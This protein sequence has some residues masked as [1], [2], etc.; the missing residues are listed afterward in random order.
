MG[1]FDKL[2]GSKPS[3]GAQPATAAVPKTEFDHL[4][5]KYQ[6]VLTVIDQQGVRLSNLHAENGKLVIV[7]TA[8]TQEAANRVWDQ[9]KLFSNYQQDLLIDLKVDPH[10][11]QGASAASLANPQA[12]RT[13]V[14]Q[15]G[16]TL[17]KIARQFYGDANDYM[18][19]F[20]ANRDKL[21]D[22][23]KIMPGQELRIP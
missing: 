8:P 14:V 22:P 1:I 19:I 5:D 9:V 11:V 2:F 20:E 7:G 4:K 13:Y 17:S 12:Y 6:P 10:N 16:D 21:W 18:R 23:N 3:G 15:R